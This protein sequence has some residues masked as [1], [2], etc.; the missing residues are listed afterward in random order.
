MWNEDARSKIQEADP[1]IRGGVCVSSPGFYHHSRKKTCLL[2]L[3]TEFI[4]TKCLY[5]A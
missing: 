3:Y 1:G 5:T 4:K 2:T